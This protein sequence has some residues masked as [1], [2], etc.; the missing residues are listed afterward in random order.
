MEI[1]L[2]HVTK[3]SKAYSIWEGQIT[4]REQHWSIDVVTRYYFLKIYAEWVTR[5]PWVA[6]YTL[7]LTLS[8]QLF[9]TWESLLKKE[10]F[11]ARHKCV[12]L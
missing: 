8:T 6:A 11:N 7:L 3:N 12:C 9:S 2:L 5:K 10:F 4:A 1:S